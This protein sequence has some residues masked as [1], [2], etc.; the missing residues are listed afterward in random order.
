M[1]ALKTNRPGEI[2]SPRVKIIHFCID[3]QIYISLTSASLET[4]LIGY[5]FIWCTYGYLHQVTLSGLS[6]FT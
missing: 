5:P 2:L 4:F 3:T 1:N 6:R